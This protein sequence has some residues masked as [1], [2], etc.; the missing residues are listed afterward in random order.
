MAAQFVPAPFLLPQTLSTFRSIRTLHTLVLDLENNDL[1][2]AGAHALAV[3]PFPSRAH[4][5]VLPT[6][7]PPTMSLSRPPPVPSGQDGRAPGPLCQPLWF[8]AG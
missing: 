4:P 8:G 1:E 6:Q 3:H 2:D 5:S 7:P